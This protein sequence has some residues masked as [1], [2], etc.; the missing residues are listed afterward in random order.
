MGRRCKGRTVKHSIAII[1]LLSLL[2]AACE[3]KE[4][5]APTK[6]AETNAAPVEP[7]TNT[8]GDAV[9]V[10]ENAQW[11]ESAYADTVKLVQAMKET[12]KRTAKEGDEPA[13]YEVP[14]KDE[15]MA[16]CGKLPLEMQHCLVLEHAVENKESC[17]AE[18][19][20]LSQDARAAYTELMGK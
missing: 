9:A 8:G 14:A 1:A 13:E 15:Y 6:T 12:M 7:A 19:E 20:A 5:E 4:A 3:K 11:C 17:Q 10:G 2:T 16:L 18:Q